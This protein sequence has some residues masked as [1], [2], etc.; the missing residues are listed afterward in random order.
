MTTRRRAV[1]RVKRAIRHMAPRHIVRTRLTRRIVERFAEKAGLVYFGYVDQRDDHRFVRGHTVSA[2]HIDGHYSIGTVRG[3]D[4]VLL[5]R[6]DVLVPRGGKKEQRYH[7]LI[8]TIDL[9]SPIDVPHLYVGHQNRERAFGE[10]YARLTPLL[11]GATGTY[12]PQFTG[13]YT[14]YGQP[15]HVIEIEQIITPEISTVIA[16]HFHGASIEIED[17]TVYLYIESRYP[18]E[19]LLEKML[20]NSLWLAEQI[21]TQLLKRVATTM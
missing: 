8:L 12:P 3:Y 17:N 5:Q 21:D 20:S 6:N 9:H 7:W 4:V 2:T 10:T 18:T 19:A 11:I 1:V 14:V 16:T 13:N 15:S